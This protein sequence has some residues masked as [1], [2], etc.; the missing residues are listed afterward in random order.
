LATTLAIDRDSCQQ[1]G[2]HLS[3]YQN[4]IYIYSASP[5]S[6]RFLYVET[7]QCPKSSGCRAQP[8]PT[9]PLPDLSLAAASLLLYLYLVSLVVDCSESQERRNAL[10]IRSQIRSRR[11]N[12]PVGRQLSAFEQLDK[13]CPVRSP[14]HTGFSG[15]LPRA[16]RFSP[17][18]GSSS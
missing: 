4:R 1:I 15:W 5:Q 2:P 10:R 14:R 18:G 12:D 6:I 7:E 17:H 11:T 9:L 3:L 8:L 16:R 13:T